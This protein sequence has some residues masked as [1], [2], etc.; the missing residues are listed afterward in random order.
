MQFPRAIRPGRPADAR[1]VLDSWARSFRR[2][3]FAGCV[4]ED[5]YPSV[6][7]ATATRLL[8]TGTL[9]VA[10]NPDEPDQILGWALREPG[11][12]HYVYVKDP[13][14][15]DGIARDLLARAPLQSFTHRTP[16]GD[17]L[18]ARVAPWLTWDPVPARRSPR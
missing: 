6:V 8:A 9:E 2:S 13:W 17:R 15:R 7:R 4:P 10:C 5:L 14:R 18:L 3:P 12:L 16:A 1:F 11:R